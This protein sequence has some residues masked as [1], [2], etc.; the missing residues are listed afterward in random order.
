MFQK[1]PYGTVQIH[2]FW[3]CTLRP[4][5]PFPSLDLD[6]EPSNGLGSTNVFPPQKGGG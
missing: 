5:S 2:P 4:T 6:S 3:G 1:V